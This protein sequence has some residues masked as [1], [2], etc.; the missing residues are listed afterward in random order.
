MKIFN[1]CDDNGSGTI[2]IEELEVISDKLGEPLT[3]EE[4]EDIMNLLD[5]DDDGSVEFDAFTQVR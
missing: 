5:D 3:Q 2:E 1:D 4:M